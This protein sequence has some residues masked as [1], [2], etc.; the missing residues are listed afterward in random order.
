MPT[1]ASA[2]PK[3]SSDRARA[4]VEFVVVLSLRGVVRRVAVAVS[5]VFAIRV[6]NRREVASSWLTLDR[7]PER[8][9]RAERIVARQLLSR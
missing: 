6:L 2:F 3:L 8:P 5:A 1:A 4:F 9:S 7:A